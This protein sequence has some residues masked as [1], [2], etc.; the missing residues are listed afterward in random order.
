MIDKEQL[1]K[2]LILG[3]IVYGPF[4][5]VDD[6]HNLVFKV[7]AV[8]E[9]VISGEWAAQMREQVMLASAVAAAEIAEKFHLVTK[10][11]VAKHIYEAI[12]VR[13]GLDATE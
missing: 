9:A 3:S 2:D 12:C 11:N 1:I 6:E 7:D 5:Y 8:A 10:D 4:A 13:F